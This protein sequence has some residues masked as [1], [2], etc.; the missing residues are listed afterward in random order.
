MHRFVSE[1]NKAIGSQELANPLQD[2]APSL[3]G[4][5][6]ESGV[7]KATRSQELADDPVNKNPPQTGASNESGAIMNQEPKKYV[8]PTYMKS[9]MLAY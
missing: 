7:D 6:S 5:K 3:S 4:V 1:E 8:W 2:K 9:C